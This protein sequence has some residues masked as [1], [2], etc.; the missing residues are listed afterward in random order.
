MMKRGEEQFAY[1][2]TRESVGDGV[3]PFPPPESGSLFL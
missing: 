1:A 3:I 2:I